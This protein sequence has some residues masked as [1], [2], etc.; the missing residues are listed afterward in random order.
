M[1]DFQPEKGIGEQKLGHLGPAV[2]KN[3][4]AP[5]LM[6][7]LARIGMFIEM[8]AVKKTEAMA[9]SWEMRRDP[10]KDDTHIVPVQGIHQVFKILPASRNGWSAQNNR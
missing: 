1:I 6:L 5:V 8:G 2:I 10:V 4:G 7:S 9:V 3:I